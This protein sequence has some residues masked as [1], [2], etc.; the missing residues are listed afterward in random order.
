MK[1][2]SGV[3]LGF[4]VLI[5][6]LGGLSLMNR[7]DVEQDVWRP[8][9]M[10]SSVG[11]AHN[12]TYSSVSYTSGASEATAVPVV[13]N[14][15]S[16][17]RHRTVSSYA[18]AHRSPMANSQ[19]PIGGM[20]SYSSKGTSALYTTSS[21]TMKSFGNGGMGAGVAMSGGSVRAT[22]S[23]P[24]TVAAVVSMPSLP[25]PAFSSTS[26][27]AR[28]SVSMEQLL[29]SAGSEYLAAASYQGIG[30]TTAGGPMGMRGRRNAP[31]I[32][33]GYFGWLGNG[34]YWG[35]D[36]EEWANGSDQVTWDRLRALYVAATGDV[37]F[38]NEEEWEAFLAWF[39]SMQEDENFGWYWA[40]V[41]DAIPFLLLLCALYAWVV[42][43]RAKKQQSSK[44]C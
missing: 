6:L 16:L 41:S 25:T 34:D 18:P 43:R 33:Y 7:M 15:G 38:S 9:D 3:L 40:P 39:N 24:A 1:I 27:A 21:A 23:Q 31:G 17:F 28:S 26:S 20:P 36:Y 19:Y 44:Q 22:S 5:C 10:Y 12:S 14:A 13:S 8:A 11:G 30:K 42:Y 2:K 32:G 29:A 35:E 37:D 4:V